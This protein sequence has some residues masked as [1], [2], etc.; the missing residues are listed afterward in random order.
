MK[1]VVIGGTGLVGSKLVGKLR[2]HGH[3]A[4]IAAPG[5]GV[6]TRAGSDLHRALAGA[7]VVVD[8]S[9]VG[10]LEQHVAAPFFEATTRHLL[11]AARRAGIQHHVTLSIVGTERLRESSYFRARLHR[12]HLVRESGVPYT[13]LR[14][15]QFFELA[16]MIAGFSTRGDNVHLPPVLIQ[17]MAADD[18]AAALGHVAVGRPINGNV[19]V[20]GPAQM[21]LDVFIRQALAAGGEPRRVV[22]DPEAL[23]FGARVTERLLLPEP[24]GCRGATT[25]E[26]WLAWNAAGLGMQRGSA[27]PGR[28][29]LA[30]AG[31]V[32]KRRFALS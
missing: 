19:E 10:S 9:N 16:R 17:P 13:L 3:E 24:H 32:T 30:G 12:E 6:D 7:T 27:Q 28:I 15:T 26:Q 23:Y 21:R 22:A 25:F 18:V 29:D 2:A 31:C 8:A 4:V 20:A 5:T 14:A 11:A 1:V